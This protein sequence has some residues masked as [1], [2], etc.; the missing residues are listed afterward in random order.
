M[1]HNPEH[2]K[3]I[4]NW[5]TPDQLFQALNLLWGFTLDVCAEPWNAKCDK[6][7]TRENDGL[8]QPWGPRDS[9]WCN[10][11]Y[12]KPAPWLEKGWIAASELGSDCTFL[13]P[14]STDT[15]WFQEMAFLG[16]L[17]FIK[18]RLAFAPPPEWDGKV[19]S[20][21]FSSVIVRYT[22]ELAH[23]DIEPECHLITREGKIS[24]PRRMV[25]HS[26]W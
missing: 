9:V 17:Y 14:S 11:P 12:S 25:Q 1:P 15:A 21:P 7:Y 5:A 18:G 23:R 13:V 26:L 4:Q 16:D 24:A 6:Y 19:E 20:A 10:P 3:H 22:P 2:L 8:A